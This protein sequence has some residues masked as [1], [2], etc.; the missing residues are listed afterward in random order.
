LT[1]LQQRSSDQTGHDEAKVTPTNNWHNAHNPVKRIVPISKAAQPATN[2][3]RSAFL[4]STLPIVNEAPEL[5][6]N[7]SSNVTPLNL[8]KQALKNVTNGF[9]ESKQGTA[10]VYHLTLPFD[11]NRRNLSF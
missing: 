9:V 4:Q 11:K 2:P 1:I 7:E 5:E 8:Q 3:M 6:A 10:S